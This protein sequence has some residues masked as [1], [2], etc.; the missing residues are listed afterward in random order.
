MVIQLFSSVQENNDRPL[1]HACL[2]IQEI[3]ATAKMTARCAINMG[4]ILWMC[5]QNLKFVA[6]PVPEI[7]AIEVL[8]GVA[9]PQ[10]WWR[11]GRRRSGMVPFET[12]LVSSYR[13]SIGLVTFPLSLRGSEILP[14]LCS[15]TRALFP[16]PPLVSPKFP[17]V[18]LDGLW[19]TKSEGVGLI[20]CAIVSKIS[21][22]GHDPPTLQ[23]D[24]RADRQMTCDR[25]TA[26]CIYSASRGKDVYSLCYFFSEVI[27]CDRAYL[28]V[29]DN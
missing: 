19:A 9:N 15:S 18:P 14:L 22:N 3:W 26:L 2:Y 13:P 8:G 7:T 23:T 29:T 27:C 11:G 28:T 16:T 17:Q 5:V 24:G 12:A 10:S 21:K 1:R 25:N 6:L 20:V 4:S